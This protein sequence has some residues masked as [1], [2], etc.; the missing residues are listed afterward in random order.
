MEEYPG[1]PYILSNSSNI[2]IEVYLIPNYRGLG[3]KF[4]ETKSKS[5]GKENSTFV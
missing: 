5:L 3:C 2:L 1:D 4:I